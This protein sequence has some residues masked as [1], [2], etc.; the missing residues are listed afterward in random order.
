MIEIKNLY[1]SYPD[2][3]V[4][5]NFSLS[6]K[7]GEITCIFGESGSGKTTLL[8]V[9][10]GLTDYE[11]YVDKID[12]SYVFQKP[13]LFPNMTVEKNLSII[14]PDK[15]QIEKVL[16]DFDMR[17][18]RFSFPKHLSGGQ[19]QRV[20][21]MRGI[22]FP[23]PLLLLDEPFMGIDLALKFKLIEKL[24]EHHNKTNGTVLMVTHDIKEA[25]ALADTIVVLKNGAIVHRFDNI[26]KD[27]EKELFELL[28]NM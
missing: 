25:V 6:L 8:N 15:E 3:E 5:K 22:L 11:G 26:T 23:A 4:F 13:N 7:E 14:N 17:E 19:E 24:K 1:K 10:A 28:I 9:I 12:C 20:A 21:L 16:D 27:T 18:K 2:T